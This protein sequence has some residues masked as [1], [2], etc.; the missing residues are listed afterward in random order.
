MQ[1]KSVVLPA[2]LEPKTAWRSPGRTLNEIS[3]NAMSAPKLFDNPFNSSANSVPTSLRGAASAIMLFQFHGL[4]Q[5]FNIPVP[6][7]AHPIW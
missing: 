3:L 1:L 4:P 2:P 5:A 6:N 7:A